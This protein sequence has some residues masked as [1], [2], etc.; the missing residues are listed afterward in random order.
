M[1]GI[2]ER[3]DEARLWGLISTRD[4][5]NYSVFY[6][7]RN[8]RLTP[9]G[10]QFPTANQPGAPVV[11]NLV[12]GRDGRT[13][14]MD[15]HLDVPFEAEP[16]D[17]E[18]HR[19]LLT[20]VRWIKE[21]GIGYAQRASGDWAS[22]SYRDVITSGEGTLKVGSQ[23]WSGF[24]FREWDGKLFD[25]SEP[26]TGPL[27]PKNVVQ[28]V[29]IEICKETE[30]DAPTEEPIE[31]APVIA[32]PRVDVESASILLSERFRGKKLKDLGVRRKQF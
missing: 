26:L 15:V 31:Q 2:I 23:I 29:S 14:A 18:S 9:L 20:L 21:K 22:V 17:L 3:F 19:E 12:V 1:Q 25:P 8:C 10:E 5:R 27:D 28:C 16:V 13:A 30:I 32:L 4:A 24:A 11:F 6:H 7:L